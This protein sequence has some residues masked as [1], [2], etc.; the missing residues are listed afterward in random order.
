DC[1]DR[2]W[3]ELLGID[4][5]ASTAQHRILTLP[6]SAR[7]DRR[8][9]LEVR[10]TTLTLAHPTFQP[11]K[12]RKRFP[13]SLRLARAGPDF[14]GTGLLDRVGGTL[15]APVLPHHRTYFSYPAVPL[16]LVTLR[17]SEQGPPARETQTSAGPSP[18]WRRGC[19]PAATSLCPTTPSPRRCPRAPRG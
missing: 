9:L 5:A 10:L 8:P 1:S 3:A 6:E 16:N 14:L 19:P 12:A 18:V 7:D 4:K 17:T 13:Y 2:L 15:T 11:D